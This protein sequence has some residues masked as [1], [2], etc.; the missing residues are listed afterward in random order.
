MSRVLSEIF[1]EEADLQM[2]AQPTT[3]PLTVD[4]MLRLHGEASG[5]VLLLL[6]SMLCVTPLAGLGTLLS[7][8]IFLIAWQWRR[9]VDPDIVPDK[10]ADWIVPRPW[11]VRLLRFLSWTYRVAD[12]WLDERWLAMSR[13]SMLWFWAIWIG[14]MGF[15][16]M[17][18]LPLGNV[19]PALSLILLSLGWMFKD[20]IA[21]LISILVGTASA[22]YLFTAMNLLVDICHR[23][24][25]TM[26]AWF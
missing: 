19:L 25:A 5:A 18:P 10:L 1:A 20:G 26:S 3:P 8:V 21:L 9:G 15:I 2:S 7:G 4:R 13:A 6:L 24:W 22:I 14:F 23:M 17:L 12:I 11:S 16:I